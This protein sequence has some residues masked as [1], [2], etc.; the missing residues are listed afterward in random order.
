MSKLI[1]RLNMKFDIRKLQK[2]VSDI[3]SKEK[4]DDK[5]IKNFG[6][7]INFRKTSSGIEEAQGPWVMLDKDGNETYKHSKHEWEN[8]FKQEFKYTEL[9]DRFKG[10]YIEYIND[11]LTEEYDIGRL[12]LILKEP[13]TCLT[14]HRDPEPRVH[15]PVFSEPGNFMIVEDEIKHLKADGSTYYT[16]T[17]KYHNVFNGSTADRIH[18]VGVILNR[19]RW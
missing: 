2:T 7:S 11:K 6:G 4:F 8:S 3:I 10:T 14:W 19:R 16:Q 5:N 12:R 1:Q 15:I 13:R 17:T 18:I 9:H